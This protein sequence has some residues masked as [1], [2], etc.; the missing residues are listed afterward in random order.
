M[1]A[2]VPALPGVSAFAVPAVRGEENASVLIADSSHGLT[3]QLQKPWKM[4][5]ESDPWNNLT[6]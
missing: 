5:W 2:E 4:R 3:P 6:R 1:A